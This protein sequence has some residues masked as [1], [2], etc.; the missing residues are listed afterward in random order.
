M[1]SSLLILFIHHTV[2]GG[3]ISP[4][5]PADPPPTGDFDEDG[6]VDLLDFGQFQ[7][8]YSGED[9]PYVGEC[10][11]VDFDCDDDV[12]LLDFESFQL[13]FTEGDEC[14]LR[15]AEDLFVPPLGAPNGAVRAL[16]VFDDGSGPALY[17]G[18]YF[19]EAGASGAKYVAEWNGAGWSALSGPLG[20]GVQGSDFPVVH[21]LCTY[22]DGSGPALYVGGSFTSAGGLPAHH[23]A[24]W[25]GSNWSSLD[26]PGGG[27]SVRALHVH[28]DG[29][30]Q[31]LYAG[32]AF[33]S[34]GGV[35][36]YNIAKWNGISWSPLVGSGGV[37]TSGVVSALTTYDDGT[38]AA[39]YA[40]GDFLQAGG[41]EVWRVAKWDGQDWFPLVGSSGVGVGFA[42]GVYALAS[43]DDGNGPSL[44]AGGW[45]ETAGGL[46]SRSMARWD[47]T[48][49]SPLID[50]GFNGTNGLVWA[51]I[52]Y[53][54]GV[55]TSLYVG[56]LFEI[57]GGILCNHLA[58]WD[59]GGWSAVSTPHGVG[60]GDKAVDVYSFV[61]FDEGTG[62]AMYA[63]GYFESAGGIPSKHVGKW[64]R[65]VAPCP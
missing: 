14:P 62:S 30:G 50:N 64:Y 42:A 63:G 35:T 41:I 59:A 7:L 39:L 24:K 18:G 29:N 22:D 32:G 37:G 49:W 25:D 5:F 55:R 57:A 26:G 48:E 45:F 46:E 36:A 4:M 15:W 11:Y 8:C 43:Y 9:E 12:D 60:M 21:A 6:D 20:V 44:Y 47:G 23:I 28:D 34:A 58:R 2:I 65:P 33:I 52:P 56:G 17:A 31:A 10:S 51:L 54:D 38:G 3:A 19:T 13:A 61:V 1:F 40:G 27:G 16:A 53:H